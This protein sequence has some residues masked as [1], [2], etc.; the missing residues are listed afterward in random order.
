MYVINLIYTAS[1]ERI[2][3]ALEAHRAFL[4]KQFDAG[5]FVAAGPKVPRDGGIILAV[6]IERDKLD[7]ILAVLRTEARALR[8]DGVQGDAAR[9]GNE[10]ADAG[11]RNTAKEI[12]YG[13]A[14][15]ARARLHQCINRA[16]A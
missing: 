15:E 12:E 14:A 5:V 4:T 8:G 7:E 2:D 13:R 6:R 10:F 3:D 11:L 16:A 1:L 9:A